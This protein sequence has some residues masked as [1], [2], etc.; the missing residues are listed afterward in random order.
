MP[1]Y[2]SP[3]NRQDLAIQRILV[4]HEVGRGMGSLLLDDIKRSLEHLARHQPAT[5]LTLEEASGYQ[6]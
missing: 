5:L 1:V 4:R 3:A 6:H 2:T